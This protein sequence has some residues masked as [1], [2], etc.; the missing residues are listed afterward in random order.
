[1]IYFTAD[2]HFGHDGIIEY[3]ARPFHNVRDMDK[4][5]IR[6]HNEVVNEEDITYFLGDLSLKGPMYKD[7]Y[8]SI[9]SKMNGFKV[10]ILGNHDTLKPFDYVELGFVSVHTMQR[11][12]YNETRY[13]LVHD[14]AVSIIDK[15]TTFLHGH[16]HSLFKQVKNC[17]NVGVDIWDY[18]PVSI[19]Q[20]IE[21]Q[22]EHEQT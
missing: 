18:K 20:I 6:F 16:L 3:E 10:L 21:L 19:L 17:I 13:N 15:T 1:M 12:T 22:G 9:L 11:I 8:H 4:K 5:L 2:H 7:Y 14:P